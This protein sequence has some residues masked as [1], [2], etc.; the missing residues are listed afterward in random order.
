MVFS[1]GLVKVLFATHNPNNPHSPNN[2]N[3]S[4]NPNHR[5]NPPPPPLIKVLFATETFAMGVITLITLITRI[6]F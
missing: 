4:H 5:N 6:T 1:R 3:N 2:P